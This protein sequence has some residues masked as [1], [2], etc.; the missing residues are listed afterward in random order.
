ME[1]L[2]QRNNIHT[3]GI[4]LDAEGQDIMAFIRGLI[5]TIWEGSEDQPLI[6]DGA[7]HIAAMAGHSDTILTESTFIRRKRLSLERLRVRQTWSFAVTPYNSFR[8]SL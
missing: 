2:N 8:T 7:H 6:L 4:P 5:Q 3:Q 1:N